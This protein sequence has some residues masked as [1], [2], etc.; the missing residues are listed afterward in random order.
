[1]AYGVRA[2]TKRTFVNNNGIGPPIKISS[3]I[4]ISVEMSKELLGTI[5]TERK[6]SLCTANSIQ[7]SE[8]MR[9]RVRIHDSVTEYI[10]TVCA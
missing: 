5:C 8:N 4:I 1:M 7:T 3:K 10:K 2:N 6:P 9:T